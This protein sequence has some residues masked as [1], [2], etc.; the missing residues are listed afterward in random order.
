MADTCTCTDVSFIILDDAF[1]VSGLSTKLCDEEMG[2]E[3]SR[4]FKL[5]F[6]S[7]YVLA[8]AR[9]AYSVSCRPEVTGGAR[10]L[11]SITTSRSP[12]SSTDVMTDS[13]PSVL[14]GSRVGGRVCVALSFCFFLLP[15]RNARGDD[16]VIST[17]FLVGASLLF[18]PSNVCCVTFVVL[19]C[20][21][22]EE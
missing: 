19:S 18:S 12:S 4:G 13:S 17:G 11:V 10:C 3:G 20:S 8:E 14:L 6:I 15:F 21:M 7:L 5:R 16:L 2:R 22:D 1:M 9:V